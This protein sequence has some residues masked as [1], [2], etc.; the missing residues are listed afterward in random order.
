MEYRTGNETIVVRMLPGEDYLES[1]TQVCRE[2]GTGTAVVLS[3]IGQ[4]RDVQIGYFAGPGDYSPEKFPG[5]CEL[6]SVSG[7]I[8][9]TNDRY[10]PH[11]HALLGQPDKS[12]I[13][14][15]LISGT[16]EI[17]NETVL[18]VMDIPMSRSLNPSTGL[19]DLVP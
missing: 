13:G 18:S 14:G 19:W 2:S 3:S 5:P 16:V 9:L 15:H 10:I 17:T 4:L 7:S 6:L 1:L 11:L 12:V 8:S